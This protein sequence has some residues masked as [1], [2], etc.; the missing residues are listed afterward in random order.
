MTGLR[1]T[2][3]LQGDL[4]DAPVRTQCGGPVPIP[5]TAFD[6][7]ALDDR[8]VIEGIAHENLA[9]LEALCDQVLSRGLADDAVPAL[10]NLWSRFR[11]FGINS[12][13]REQLLALETL[14]NIGTEQSRDTV[15]CIVEESG[16]APVL[17]PHAL[18]AAVTLKVRFSLWQIKE[19]LA[20]GRPIVRARAF[21]LARWVSP[22]IWILQRGRNDPDLSV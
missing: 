18:K 22:P 6:P 20:D 5:E 21:S 14:A 8:Q 16:L 4:F 3:I 7:V 15:R 12:P 17:L 13:C 9:K 2:D 19:W 1:V 10:R 11:G